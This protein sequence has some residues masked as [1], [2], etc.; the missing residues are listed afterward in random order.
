M[1]ATSRT[2]RRSPPPRGASSDPALSAKDR[3]ATRS[4]YRERF[5][6]YACGKNYLR[7][8]WVNVTAYSDL[9]ARAGSEGGARGR[10]RGRRNPICF[11]CRA[12]ASSARAV[13]SPAITGVSPES[14]RRWAGKP[15]WRRLK[16]YAARSTFRLHCRI[17]IEPVKI[18]GSP[19][20]KFS[21]VMLFGRV[22]IRTDTNARNELPCADT[23]TCRGEGPVAPQDP[24]CHRGRD[25][26]GRSRSRRLSPPGGATS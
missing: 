21:L 5:R 26:R 12:T 17:R 9:A 7:S 15:E 18:I 22:L 23:S 19:V 3:A 20:S 11:V 16:A 4:I 24:G 10:R 2:S 1:H 8:R 6:K 14:A 13:T 25:R